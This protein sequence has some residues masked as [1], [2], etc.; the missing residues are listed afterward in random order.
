MKDYLLIDKKE[1]LRMNEVRERFGDDYALFE[2]DPIYRNA[3]ALCILQIGE[4]VGKLTDDFREQHPAVPW[5]QIKAMRNIVAH[6]YG[7]VD[8]ETTWEIITSDIPDLKRYCQ[9]ILENNA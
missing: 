5:R 4:L 1:Y 6:S 9:V 3:A 2:S 8:L 7:S